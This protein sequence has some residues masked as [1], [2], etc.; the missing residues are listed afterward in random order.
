MQRAAAGRARSRPEGPEIGVA[1][2]VSSL[3]YL[4]ADFIGDDEDAPPFCPTGLPDGVSVPS[5][6]TASIA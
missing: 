2:V 4:F 3:R 6:A 1:S 5:S